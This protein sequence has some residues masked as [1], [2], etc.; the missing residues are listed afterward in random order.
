MKPAFP[1]VFVKLQI[2]QIKSVVD[3]PFAS[4]SDEKVI[5]ARGTG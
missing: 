1:L 3:A 5:A 4:L 2:L